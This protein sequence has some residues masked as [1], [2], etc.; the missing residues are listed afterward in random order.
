VRVPVTTLDRVYFPDTGQTKADLL[1]YY[2]RMAPVLLPHLRDRPMI[3]RRFPEGAGGPSFYQHEAGDV[4]GFVRTTRVE[5]ESGRELD[6]VVGGAEATLIYFAARGAIECHTWHSRVDLPER[7]DRLVLDLDPA[8]G[9]PFGVTCAIALTVRE[10]LADHG[11][12]GFA[13]TSGSRGL[14]VFV[15]LARRT[16]YGRVGDAA[17]RL[18][19]LVAERHPREATLTR[20]PDDRPKGTVYV[21]F[22]QNARAK[23]VAAP[24][25]VRA[26][27][28]ATVSTPLTWD[29]VAAMPDPTAFTIETVPRRVER[30]GELF[31]EVLRARQ[32]LPRSLAGR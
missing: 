7:P 9:L 28:A 21:D 23:S 32:S 27:P 30:V 16:T 11:L 8:A 12:V 1:R 4:P 14:H 26:R 17:H 10:V 20:D 6:Y 25:S 3:L 15:P 29:E 22:L 24:Y 5:A 31:D 2:H 18:A 19:E 13:K